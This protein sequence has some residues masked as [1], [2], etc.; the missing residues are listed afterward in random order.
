MN[1]L[2]EKLNQGK[3]ARGVWMMLP[4]VEST[5][6]VAQLPVDWLLIDTEHAPIDDLTLAR[7]VGSVVDLSGPAPIVR[8]VENSIAAIKR[9]L[10]VGA[11]GVLVPMINSAEEARQAVMAAK[12]PPVGERSF[13][14]PFAPLAFK[15][16]GL[17]YLKQAN[18]ETLLIVQ[19]ESRTALDHIEEILAVPGIDMVLI[20]PADLS[21]S[22]G[23]ELDFSTPNPV[24]EEAIE[25]ILQAA[26]RA[27][28]PAGIYCPDGATAARRIAQGF[29]LV[30]VAGDISA[31]LGG[32]R[33]QLEASR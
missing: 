18:R 13:G 32:I 7:I 30:N 23:L 6:L 20:G 17:D 25:T 3:A 19:A 8:V 26:K 11:W 5:R 12:F 16:N 1:R 21:I 31:M 15:T 22:L 29:Q 33:Q 27:G 4:S 24:L 28:L 2:R 14:S 9:A 10:D